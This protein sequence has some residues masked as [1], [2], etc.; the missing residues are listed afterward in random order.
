MGDSE[1]LT[2]DG[3]NRPKRSNKVLVVLVDGFR[4]LSGLVGIVAGGALTFF[5]LEELAIEN[6]WRLLTHGWAENF[7]A[8]WQ[9]N[10][11]QVQEDQWPSVWVILTEGAVAA[12]AVSIVFSYT[13]NNITQRISNIWQRPVTLPTDVVR[14]D[15]ETRDWINKL[16][17]KESV[18]QQ[19]E[20]VRLL[21]D[22]NDLKRE[23][24]LLQR[25]ASQLSDALK[26][27][28]ERLQA[29]ERLLSQFE[30]LSRLMQSRID[31]ARQRYPISG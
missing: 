1:G 23:R 2:E 6:G 12:L 28:G 31:R 20:I 13:V 3:A 19:K 14:A 4:A 10:I 7:V 9:M 15:P 11:A 29:N 18:D 27:A 21:N 5:K 24:D 26:R 22:C 25:K 8:A 17:A 16:T 30:K